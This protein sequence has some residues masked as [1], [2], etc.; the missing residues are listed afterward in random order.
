MPEWPNPMLRGICA[1]GGAIVAAEAWR[2]RT[3]PVH[4]HS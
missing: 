2:M 3:K 4:R 1:H